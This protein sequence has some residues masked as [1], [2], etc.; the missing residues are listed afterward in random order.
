MERLEALSSA[1]T[2][3]A[4]KSELDALAAEFERDSATLPPSD[5]VLKQWSQRALSISKR[6]RESDATGRNKLLQRLQR[7][8]LRFRA[9]RVSRRR[10]LEQRDRT[11]TLDAL[12]NLDSTWSAAPIDS[13]RQPLAEA[14]HAQLRFADGLAPIAPAEAPPK[15]PALATMPAKQAAAKEA[16]PVQRAAEPSSAPV[17]NT[18]AVGP[19]RRDSYSASPVAHLHPRLPRTIARD[20]S[21]NA[22]QPV[23]KVRVDTLAARHSTRLDPIMAVAGRL[24]RPGSFSL[25]QEIARQWLQTKRFKVPSDSQESFE[26]AVADKGHRAIAVSSRG[27][28]ALQAETSDSTMRGR[29]WRVEMVLI[30]AEP[31]PAVSVTL[32]AISPAAQPSPPPSIPVLLAQLIDQ[33]GLLDTETGE[34]FSA[35]ATRIDE[36]AALHRMLQ[37]LWSPSR[38]QPVLVLSTYYKQGQ[39]RQAHLLD[40]DGLA[41]KLR[42]LA[43]VYVLTQEM[44][45]ALTD[46]LT[47]RFAV[48]GAT[49][50]LFRPGFTP[51]DDPSLHPAWSPD[52]LQQQCINLQMLSALFVR[53]AADASLRALEQEDA[54]PPFDRVREQILRRQIEQAREQAS[55]AALV[56]PVSTERLEALQK[57]LADEAALRQMYEED[58]ERQRQEL[59]RLRGERD[60]LRTE[61]DVTHARADHLQARINSLQQRMSEVEISDAPVF[62]DDWVNL[63]VWCAEHLADRVVLTPKAIRAARDSDYAEVTF[64]YQVLLFLADFYVPCRRG[65]LEGGN[66][67]LEQEEKRLGIEISRVNRAAQEHRTRDTYSTIYKGRRV[68]LDM[69]VKGNSNRDPRYCFR[70]YFHWHAEEERLIVGWFPGHLENAL[71]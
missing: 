7:L 61:R 37:L 69:H 58:N 12:H 32:T 40:P 55:A 13:R 68:S 33:I 35:R 36:A 53:D 27:V 47:K 70:L 43:K 66:A 8:Q 23:G 16:E 6:L 15:K 21:G 18:I 59:T 54:I 45:W 22:L 41:A 46:A 48:A 44:S 62:P 25:A 10:Y 38:H 50:R 28:W 52:V 20:S 4:L 65:A 26:I 67:A 3:T 19:A 2:L 42:G 64:A 17:P 24:A 39:G 57:A 60:A 29:R 71:T 9:L 34:L 51:E 1:V 49:V 63:E 11:P 56:E 5:Q 31:T 30:D 14:I